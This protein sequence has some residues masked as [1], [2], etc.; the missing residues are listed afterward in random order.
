MPK[1][2][3]AKK[4]KAIRLRVRVPASS[5]ATIL[6][7][8]LRFGSTGAAMK[9]KSRAVRKNT[10]PL[11]YSLPVIIFLTIAGLAVLWSVFVGVPFSF[12]GGG[13]NPS[14]LESVSHSAAPVSG[15]LI[16]PVVPGASSVSAEPG[17]LAEVPKAVERL[18]LIP[19]RLGYLNVRAGPGTNYKLLRQ[20]N[21]GGIFEYTTIEDGWYRIILEDGAPGW[22]Y[23]DYAEVINRKQ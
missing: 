11:F 13:D 4:T 14:N 22:I 6:P 5:G 23:G 17:V 2:E 8:P 12:I 21:D 10:R 7:A 19:N 15:E 16:S 3:L 9:T 1:T 20:I 18:N